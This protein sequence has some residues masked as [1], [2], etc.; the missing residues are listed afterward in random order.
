MITDALSFSS[1]VLSFPSASASFDEGVI[2]IY[3]SSSSH[4]NADGRASINIVVQ[5]DKQWINLEIAA[6][7]AHLVDPDNTLRMIHRP[8]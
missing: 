3:A 2:I 1:M 8:L 7:S 4:S 6:K 5:A